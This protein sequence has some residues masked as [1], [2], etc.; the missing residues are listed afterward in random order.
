MDFGQLKQYDTAHN[1]YHYPDNTFVGSFLGNPPMNFVRGQVRP[2]R[3]APHRGAGRLAAFPVPE[4]STGGLSDGAEVIV[5]MRPET[6]TVLAE[7]GDRRR[8]SPRRSS[9]SSRRGPRPC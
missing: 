5:G 9:R 2:R 3:R 6:M 1:V 7:A 4:A 8:A